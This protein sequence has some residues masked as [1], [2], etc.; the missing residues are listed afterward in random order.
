[1]T[2]SDPSWQKPQAKTQPIR[3][4]DPMAR[5]QPVTIHIPPRETTPPAGCGLMSGVLIALPFAAL[6]AL[7]LV[8]LLAPLPINLLVLGIDRAPDGTVTSRT[9]TIILMTVIPLKP[10]VRM[11]SIPRDL[12]VPIPGHGENRINTAHFY[13]EADAPGSGPTAA[14][15]VIKDNFQVDLPYYLRIQ[16][17]GFEQ[18]IDAMGGVD[19]NLPTSELGLEAGLNHLDGLQALALVRDRQG[20]DDFYRMAHGQLLIKSALAQL[21]K[22][23]SWLRLPAILSALKQCTNNNLPVWQLPR[24]GLALI[25]AGSKGMDNR[26]LPRE[27]TT[28]TITSGGA[29]V[30]MPKWELILPLVKEMFGK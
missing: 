1:M 20:T 29:D 6:A 25:R 18:V 16:F 22:P 24:L 26:T 13:A 2:L 10:T 23:S 27:M 30:L 28:P 15:K 19:V 8:Y 7:L 11:L 14:Q 9:D 21:L 4:V 3:P 17:D 5:F 12:W